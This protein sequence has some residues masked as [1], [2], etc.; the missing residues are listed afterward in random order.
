MNSY[1]KLKGILFVAVYLLGA[2]F[3]AKS[4]MLSA[5]P[6]PKNSAVTISKVGIK[7]KESKVVYLNSQLAS[8]TSAFGEPGSVSNER[9]K[10]NGK[11]AKV[12]QYGNSKLYFVDNILK[13]YEIQDAKMVVG[14]QN[15]DLI[16]VGDHISS[17]TSYAPVA[18]LSK[19][20]LVA[21]I[22]TDGGIATNYYI[23][24]DVNPSNSKIKTIRIASY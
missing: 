24:I 9:L 6:A 20:S 7:Y 12:L 16:M 23:Q 22:V 19:N 18:T 14:Q 5:S 10:P 4:E 15:G 13:A 11:T 3:Y 8:V 2:F 17:V 21:N 1:I